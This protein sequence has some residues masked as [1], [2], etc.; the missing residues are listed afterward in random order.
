MKGAKFW[1]PVILSL[2]A[3]PVCLFLGVASG[4]AGH[5]DYVLARI[6]FPF[7]ML[8]ASLFDS[9]TV[10]FIVLGV[11]Q[12]PLYGI[13]L[14]AANVRAKLPPAS[15]VLLAAHA[16]FAVACFVVPDELFS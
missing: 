2:V 8:S 9:I 5:G 7:T 10:P 14:G 6:L 13:A 15:A 1:L 4:G 12:F 11:I 3:T 16:L